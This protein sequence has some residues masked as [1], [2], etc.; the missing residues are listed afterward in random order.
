LGVL[1]PL[2]AWAQRG[3]IPP[4]RPNIREYLRVWKRVKEKVGKMVK[5]EVRKRLGGS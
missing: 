2:K 1:V 3:S 5:E 4:D